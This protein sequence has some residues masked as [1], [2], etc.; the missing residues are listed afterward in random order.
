[1]SLLLTFATSVMSSAL[2]TLVV[3]SSPR[4]AASKHKGLELLLVLPILHALQ[5]LHC[6]PEADPED[7]TVNF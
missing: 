6:N 3:V 1:M 2:C 5:G 4:A 7:V